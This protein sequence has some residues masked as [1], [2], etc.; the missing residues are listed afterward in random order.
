M[1]ALFGHELVGT[2]ADQAQRY[3]VRAPF[4]SGPRQPQERSAVAVVAA[5]KGPSTDS[6][7]GPVVRSLPVRRGTGQRVGGAAGGFDRGMDALTCRR[8]HPR[9]VGDHA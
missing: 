3:F 8:K 9:V 7:T 1:L 6:T 2:A 4:G 5:K